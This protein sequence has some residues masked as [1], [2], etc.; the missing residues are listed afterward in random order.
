MRHSFKVILMALASVLVVGGMLLA[1]LRFGLFR[2][3]CDHFETVIS[4]DTHGAV[5]S[6]FDACT[7]IGSSNVAR[8]DLIQPNGHRIQIFTFVPW[9]GEISYRGVTAK[10]PFE[11]A[12][13]WLSPTDLRI[14]IGTVGHVLQRRTEVDGV[15]VT[16]DIGAE[17]YK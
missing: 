9:G 2:H 14:S 5:A 13:T 1:T 3:S 7:V 15:H 4:R 11:P 8:V 16:Y 6:V 12:A 17:L 10:S